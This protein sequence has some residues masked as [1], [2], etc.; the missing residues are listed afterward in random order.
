MTRD[1]AAM[2]DR[3]GFVKKPLEEQD[4][5]EEIRSVLTVLKSGGYSFEAVRSRVSADG[6]GAGRPH[7]FASFEAIYKIYSAILASRG[8]I[9]F[10]DMIV[11]AAEHVR[12]GRYRRGGR[13]CRWRRR[14]VRRG[15]D[16]GRWH[17]QHGR[18]T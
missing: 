3:V 13:L 12:S 2:H 18:R 1:W 7:S 15:A 17:H 9:D 11:L 4:L 8:E 14:A 5:L 6:G 16:H 10:D